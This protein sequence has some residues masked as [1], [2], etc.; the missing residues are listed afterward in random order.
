MLVQL[1]DNFKAVL[2]MFDESYPVNY[3]VDEQFKRLA[4]DLRFS[5]DVFVGKMTVSMPHEE[6][7]KTNYN[8]EY[9]LAKKLEPQSEGLKVTLPRVYLFK[10]GDLVKPIVWKD[11][12]KFDSFEVRAFIRA[13]IPEVRVVLESCIPE[14]DSLAEK[15]VADLKN[16]GKV[17]MKKAKDFVGKLVDDVRQ[18]GEVYVKIMDKVI[19]RGEMFLESERERVFNILKGAKISNAKKEQIQKRLNILASFFPNF[20]TEKSTKEELW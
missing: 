15:F 14:L 13:N 18:N 16:E 6:D 5:K 12:E 4:H 1:V 11:D 8:E 3:D 9:K 10:Q 19:E 20:N 2:V 17:I 7:A